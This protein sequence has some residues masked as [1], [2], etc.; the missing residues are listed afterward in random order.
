MLGTGP[1]T[2]RSLSFPSTASFVYLLL[3]LPPLLKSVFFPLSLPS[4]LI[5]CHQSVPGGL[6]EARA[7]PWPA[8]YSWPGSLE[9][10]SNDTHPQSHTTPSSHIHIHSPL[11]YIPYPLITH[12][13]SCPA[14]VFIHVHSPSHFYS[15]PSEGPSAFRPLILHRVPPSCVSV[16]WRGGWGG[17]PA[18]R[19][20]TRGELRSVS[21]CVALKHQYFP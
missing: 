12:T 11:S 14:F 20:R 17:N 5:Q 1:Y 2:V 19:H 10:T 7:I 16:W 21:H 6:W 13:P 8:S 4:Y 9:R 3:F 18:G 15:K